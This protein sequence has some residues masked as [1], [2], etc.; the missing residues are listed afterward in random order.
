[1]TKDF[2][3][4]KST[5][6]FDSPENIR[7]NQ[8]ISIL[9]IGDLCQTVRAMLAEN[10]GIKGIVTLS[11]EAFST[12]PPPIRTNTI[13]VKDE[14]EDPL[15]PVED[16]TKTL[17]TLRK[18]E[19]THINSLPDDSIVIIISNTSDK[20]GFFTKTGIE[21][22]RTIKDASPR[23]IIQEILPRKDQLLQE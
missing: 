18:L 11:H 12:I 7:E 3:G 19:S 2:A 13:L 21:N 14:E 6:T 4:P 1:M 8:P 17:E 9:I 10:F 20:L 22:Q 16:R 15:T 23:A 5:P